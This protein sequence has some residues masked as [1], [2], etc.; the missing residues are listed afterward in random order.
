MQTTPTKHALVSVIIPAYN[1]QDYIK[2][3]LDSVLAQSYPHFEVLIVN[4]GSTD[5]TE[6]IIDTYH[7]PRVRLIPQS[8]GGLSN[9]RNTG[10][11]NAQGYYLAFLDADDY[12][13]PEKLEKQIEVLKH[14]PEVSFCSIQTRVETPEGEFINT[15]LCPELK[16]SILHT[17][18]FQNAAIAGSGSSVMLTAELQKQA[19]FFDESLHSLE[20]IDMWM[21]Y[22]AI[23][24]YCCIP[25]TLSVIIK[26]TDSMSRNLET[27]RTSAI[28]VLTKNKS[29]LDTTAQKSFWHSCYANMLYD[30]AKWE[31]RSGF[32][33]IAIQH[34]LLALI[35]AP[36]SKGRLCL[37]L[38]FAIVFNRPLG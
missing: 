24:K 13:I 9:A 15:W 25:E 12:W 18:F 14:H 22:A 8:N 3:A 11:K 28:K 37:G 29:L 33:I 19:G 31:A 7:D 16:S 6:T 38:L 21:R 27:M 36:K 34:T 2:K 10:I 1:A 23:A 4:D 17:I 26:R 5:N 32:K 20:D 30:Y 35:Y